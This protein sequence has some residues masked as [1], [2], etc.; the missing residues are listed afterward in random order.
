MSRKTG[1]QLQFIYYLFERNYQFFGK[2]LKIDSHF[3]LS[4]IC[5]QI[6]NNNTTNN[7]SM[8]LELVAQRVDTLEKQMAL[9]LAKNASDEVPRKDK[10]PKKDKKADSDDDKPKTKRTSGYILYSNAHRDEV[11]DQLSDGENKAK[12]TDIMKKL[13][14]NWKALDDDGKEK[15]N[16]KAKELKDAAM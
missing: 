10:K 13:A 15:W 6:T 14:E 2:S 3:L 16:S 5:I 12:N 11:K 9:L 7:M 8:T 1:I 4:S